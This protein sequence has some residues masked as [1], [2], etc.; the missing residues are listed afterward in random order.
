[1]PF[2]I[3]YCH[4]TIWLLPILVVV[5]LGGCLSQ[6][7]SAWEGKHRDDLIQKW[8]PPSQETTLSKG[9]GSLVYI[10]AWA[11]QYGANTCRMVFNTDEAGIIKSWSYYG[12]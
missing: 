11:N 12:C 3:R 7:M 4:L 5:L 8:G 1:M 2:V 9:G 10:Q 6:K